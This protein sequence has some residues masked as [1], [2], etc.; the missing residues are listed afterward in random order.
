MY[1]RERNDKAFNLNIYKYL[2]TYIYCIMTTNNFRIN[3][4]RAMYV[5]CKTEIIHV[6][7]S[8]SFIYDSQKSLE[9]GLKRLIPPMSLSMIT[10]FTFTAIATRT[11]RLLS[12][13]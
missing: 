13:K 9:K 2:Y 4:Y 7:F 8:W 12:E 6:P 10:L 1:D 3:E 5:V 11:K